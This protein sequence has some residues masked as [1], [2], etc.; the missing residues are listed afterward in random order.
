MKKLIVSFLSIAL[1]ISCNKNSKSGEDQNLNKKFDQYKDRFVIALW[2]VY[3]GWASGAGY[4]K[5]DSVLIIPNQKQNSREIAFAKANLDSLQQFDIEKLSD[6]NKTDLKMIKNQLESAIFYNNELKSGEWDPSEYNVCGAFAEILNGS[7]DSLEVR[8]HTFNTKMNNI[9]AYYEAAKKNIKNPTVEHTELAIAQNLG[10]SS[11]F[12]ED[13]K[14]ALEKSK[15][16]E[17]EKKEMTAKAAVSLKAITDYTDWLKKLPNNTPRSFR[18]GNA[19]YAK[20][21]AFDIESGYNADE[22][23]KIAID[24]KKDLHDKMFVLADK[25]WAKYKGNAVKPTDKLELIKQ[26]IDQISLKHTTPEKF[27]SEIEKQI[28]ELTAY[29]KAK[30]LLYIDPS[31]PLVVRKEPAYMAGVAGASISA[32]G[33]YDKNANTYYNVGSMS[34]WTK[35][36]AESYLR[37]YN[38]YI[39]QI[40][41][42]H[43]AIPGHYTQLVYSNQSPSIIKSILGNG[44]MIEGWAVYAEK[45]MLESG[46][47]NSDEMWLMYYKWNLRTTCN[48]IL[49]ISV[50]TKNM[51][52][53]D[54]IKLLTREAFQ[55][56]AEADGKWKRVTLSQVQLCSYFTGYTEIYNL[57]EELKKKQGDKFNL[58]K[59]HEK[60]L[61][62][63]SAPVKYIKELMLSEE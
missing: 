45:M 21:F 47:K 28:P 18:L 58:K 53:D 42:I 3:P 30:D 20:K 9:P 59:F 36:N 13:L 52:K 22:I 46:Y 56:Q 10:G 19:L 6:N 43:E 49:D 51:S 27:Q 5:L 12:K 2:N 33:P 25:L 60:F 26:V 24:H 32:P 8:L 54:A 16:T 38:D 62:F 48:T 55:Q 57:R 1:L 31:K 61:S 4:H 63:G 35:E 7:Y 40:L 41:N 37:E 50:H 39:L 34:G 23:Y 44:A 15:L 14:S 11:A 17:D 29:V